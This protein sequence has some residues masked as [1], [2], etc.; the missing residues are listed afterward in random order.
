MVICSVDSFFMFMAYSLDFWL[1]GYH[2]IY[3]SVSLSIKTAYFQVFNGINYLY[4][5]IPL[6]FYVNEFIFYVQVV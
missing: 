1:Y 2:E 5:A 3:R 6:P 4:V